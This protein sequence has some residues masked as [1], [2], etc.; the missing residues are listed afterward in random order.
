MRL[1]VVQAGAAAA[2]AAPLLRPSSAEAATTFVKSGAI[3]IESAGGGKAPV[4]VCV[5]ELI[6]HLRAVCRLFLPRACTQVITIFDHRGCTAHANAEYKVNGPYSCEVSTAL[7]AALFRA[8]P[9]HRMGAAG[10]FHL[11]PGR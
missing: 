11:H 5:R 2:V 3:N 6:S 10:P 4:R 8:L 9:L 7:L 1:Q